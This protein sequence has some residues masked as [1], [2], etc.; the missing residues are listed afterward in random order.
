MND[1]PKRR[2]RARA[3]ALLFERGLAESRAKAQALILA[4][5]VYSAERRI[6]KPGALLELTA[7]LTVRRAPRYVSRGGD[8][9]EGALADL[10][11]DVRGAVCVDIGAATGGFT[12]CLLQHG[13]SKVYAVD[14]GRAQL[15]AKLRGDQRVTLM[16]RTN[17]RYLTAE[18]F[19]QPVQ[20]VVVDASFIG[21]DKLMPAIAALLGRGSRLL[22]LI[23]PQF[24]AGRDAARR[25]RGVIR[26]PVVREAAIAGARN[27][28]AAHGFELV[29]E[30]DSRV[31]GPKGNVE[32][33]VLA[34]R[35]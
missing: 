1:R 31:A 34:R 8:K 5:S 21:L 28:I 11:V 24:E 35:V 10:D 23:K 22:A 14:V 25:A 4:G 12:D 32:H 2:S 29:G 7:P 13:A 15:A 33:F 9:L 19:D 6:D 17:A 3:D 30:C 18:R 26:D 20:V 27:A 16:E